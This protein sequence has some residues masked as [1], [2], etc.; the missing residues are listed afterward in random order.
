MVVSNLSVGKKSFLS[1]SLRQMLCNSLIQPIFSNNKINWP[2]STW[3][4]C[5]PLLTNAKLKKR[6][7]SYKVILPHCNGVSGH[8][9]ISSLGQ[10]CRINFPLTLSFLQIP[11][12]SS[13]RSRC[14]FLRYLQRKLMIVLSITN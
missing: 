9:T 14:T 8:R 5:L 7:S 13:T 11:T 4:K 6:S 3:M 1:G 12:L 10:G 2:Q